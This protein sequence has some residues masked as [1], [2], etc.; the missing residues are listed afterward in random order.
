M[1]CG[2]RKFDPVTIM[3]K[4]EKIEERGWK[5]VWKEKPKKLRIRNP[6]FDITNHSFV[7][8]II[9]ELGVHSP[10]AF[11]LLMYGEMAWKGKDHK[12][13]SVFKVAESG[14]K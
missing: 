3:G 14:K 4:G 13:A 8:E 5:E 9:S 6:A 7:S 10:E 2:S 12:N 1:A 11:A